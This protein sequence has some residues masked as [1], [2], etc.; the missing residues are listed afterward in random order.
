MKNVNMI[1]MTLIMVFS[2]SCSCIKE[3][4]SELK[5]GSRSAIT[6]LLTPEVKTAHV[7]YG[8]DITESVEANG[9]Y[10]TAEVMQILRNT[11]YLEK[12]IYSG[13]TVQL[14]VIREYS[15]PDV[16]TIKLDP[17]TSYSDRVKLRR[18]K[19]IEDF[20]ARLEV[21]VAA[22]VSTPVLKER[23]TTSLSRN[24][25]WACGRLSR[26]KADV[27][28]LILDTDGIETTVTV[29]KKSFREVIGEIDLD[30]PD[31]LKAL[32]GAFDSDC[33]FSDMPDSLSLKD[34]GIIQ[35]HKHNAIHDER[36][37][38]ATKFWTY[39]LEKHGA[40]YWAIRTS[41]LVEL[42]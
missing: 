27:K 19:A 28:L 2:V 9:Y 15:V 36:N 29:L 4:D 8:R 35:M 41:D 33:S 10:T 30:N 7:M 13:C 5:K 12:D 34:V 3:N 26:S 40:R 1:L 39:H 16:V 20:Y 23:H 24:V 6:K 21:A 38:K 42:E 32:S 11:N 17:V 37:R 25:C 31:D 22:L 14:F 18:L